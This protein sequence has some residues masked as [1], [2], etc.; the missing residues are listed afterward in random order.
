MKNSPLSVQIWSVFAVITLCISILLSIIL[1]LTLRDFFTN[2]IYATIE[3]S[4]NLI[5]NQFDSEIYRDFIE[6]EIFG[7]KSQKLENARTVNHFLIYDQ[8]QVILSSPL[9]ME[10]LN[11]VKSEIGEQKKISQQ[12]SGEI[13][14]EKIFYVITKGRALGKDVF[15]VSYMGDS[16]REDLVQTLFRK[17]ALIM[18]LVFL[19]SWIPAIGLAKYL[20]NP[21]VS[22]EKRVK[23]LADHEWN[24]PV[25]LDRKDEIGN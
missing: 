15:L 9:S 20:S 5:F 3:N 25:Q 12:Y 23:K 8:N 7:K 17:L 1:P 16:Y 6:S 13:D 2:E 22:L 10:F 18:T 4:Q 11:K 14:N 24:E 21:L 19:F